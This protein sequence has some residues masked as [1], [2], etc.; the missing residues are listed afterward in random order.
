MI[1][2]LRRALDRYAN[3]RESL[4]GAA[5]L[6]IGLSA[7]MLVMYLWYFPSHRALWGPNGVLDYKDYVTGI[8]GANPFALYRYNDAPWFADLIYFAS[9]AVAGAYLIGIAPRVTS[10]LF[11]ITAF[12]NVNRN[13]AASDAGQTLLVLIAFLLCFVDT[14]RWA[15]LPLKLWRFKPSLL[16]AISTMLHNSGRFLVSWQICMVYWWAAFAKLGGSD[17]R[18]GTALYYVMHLDRFMWFPNLAGGIAGNIVLVSILTYTTLIFQ[19]AF[20]FLM[21]DRRYKPFMIA[22]GIGLH[23]GIGLLMGLLTFSAT[24]IIADLSLLSDGQFAALGAFGRAGI[25]LNELI[26]RRSPRTQHDDQRTREAP[27]YLRS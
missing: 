10:W 23:T 4:T 8:A 24:M 11:A 2:V 22:I 7:I 26:M 13:P 6:R 25:R 5:V 3:R 20:P 15:L 12:A 14:S 18:H 16:T 17:W 9:L 21:W 19:A 1:D 27:A